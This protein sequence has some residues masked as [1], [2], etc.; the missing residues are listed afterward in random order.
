VECGVHL[1]MYSVV[2]LR[3]VCYLLAVCS[4]LECVFNCCVFT[5]GLCIHLLA[6]CL[7]V[8]CVFTCGLCIHFLAVC[9]PVGCVFTCGVC[10]HLRG[11]GSPVCCLYDLHIASAKYTHILY[12]KSTHDVCISVIIT[13]TPLPASLTVS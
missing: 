13:G 11:L 7:P 2:H 5:C 1:Y 10:V 9:S 6:V 4:P 12:Y 3:D 8:G